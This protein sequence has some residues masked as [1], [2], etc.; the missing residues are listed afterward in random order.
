[1]DPNETAKTQ[2]IQGTIP[3]LPEMTEE[4]RKAMPD[5]ILEE[6]VPDWLATHRKLREL[7]EDAGPATT[8]ETETP[9]IDEK[10]EN[11]SSATADAENAV[12]GPL[13][14]AERERLLNGQWPHEPVEEADDAVSV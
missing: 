8:S 12:E 2:V 13:E 9:E 11:R 3:N 1:M 14:G 6:D 10:G 4:E 5:V 7:E